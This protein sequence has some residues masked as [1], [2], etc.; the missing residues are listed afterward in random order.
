MALQIVIAGIGRG[1]R[2]KVVVV[3]KGGAVCAAG[4]RCWGAGTGR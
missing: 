1:G 3:T 4:G 2:F